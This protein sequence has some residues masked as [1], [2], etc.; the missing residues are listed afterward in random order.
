MHKAKLYI[1]V[2]LANGFVETHLFHARFFPRDSSFFRHVGSF[3]LLSSSGL[4][5]QSNNLF[6]CR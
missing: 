1:V 3:D 5:E 2:C 4:C 6:A